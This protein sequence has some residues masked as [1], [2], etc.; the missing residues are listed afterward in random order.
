MIKQ[1]ALTHD[2]VRTTA[3]RVT[4]LPVLSRFGRDR[5]IFVGRLRG[6][7]FGDH[8]CYKGFCKDTKQATRRV[9]VKVAARLLSVRGQRSRPQQSMTLVRKVGNLCLHL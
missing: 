7:G 1:A 6:T 3:G 2:F 4:V 5:G 9:A 8:D